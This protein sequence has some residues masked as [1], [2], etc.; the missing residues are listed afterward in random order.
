MKAEEL[1]LRG[2]TAALPDLARVCKEGAENIA[3]VFPGYEKIRAHRDRMIFGYYVLLSFLNRRRKLSGDVTVISGKVQRS[4]PVSASLPQHVYRGQWFSSIRE[5]RDGITLL[6]PFSFRERIALRCAAFRLYR[7]AKGTAGGYVQ[8]QEFC[9][10][11][12]FLNRVGPGTVNGR[13]HYDECATWLG[14]L[15]KLLGYRYCI[16]QHGVVWRK[17][18]IPHRIPCTELFVFN[19]YSAGIF[20]EL[21]IANEDCVYTVYPFP[22]SCQFETL[23]RK[24]GYRYIGVIEQLDAG[25]VRKVRER[26]PAD[27]KTVFIIMKHPLS[28]EEYES[29]ER[30]C[31]T[32]V[33]YAEPDCLITVN[34]TLV[35]DYFRNGYKGQVFVTDQSA[36]EMFAEYPSVYYADLDSE[37]AFREYAGRPRME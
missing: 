12:A 15:K 33:K 34:S 37:T 2:G 7:K 36:V 26:F 23:T 27:E 8:W 35:L 13:G 31:V 11:A 28:K 30:T 16:Y 4:N 19:R 1:I 9:F 6:T 32:T 18:T 17:V 3:A 21:Y 25:W 29:D 14:G 22:P 10:L 20:R 5:I 24:E